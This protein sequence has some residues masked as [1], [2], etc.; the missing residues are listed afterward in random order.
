MQAIH[1]A[2][3]QPMRAAPRITTGMNHQPTL[4]TP[5]TTAFHPPARCTVK[6]SSAT[7]ITAIAMFREVSFK[8]TTGRMVSEDTEK[9]GGHGARRRQKLPRRSAGHV[10][11]SA[12]LT[13]TISDLPRE[14]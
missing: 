7:P 12:T 1:A 8:R 5:L 4:A 3:R 11:V 10:A 2:A 14:T 6:I 9:Y 13:S